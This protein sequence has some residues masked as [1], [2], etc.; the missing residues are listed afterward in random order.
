MRATGNSVPQSFPSVEPAHAP[1]L[2]DLEH[3][4]ETAFLKYFSTKE[5]LGPGREW[6]HITDPLYRDWQAIEHALCLVRCI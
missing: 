5:E 3:Q 4:A 1:Q 2:E 6:S